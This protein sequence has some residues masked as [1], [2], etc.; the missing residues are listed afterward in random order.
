MRAV[1][2]T[3][4]KIDGDRCIQISTSLQIISQSVPTP[5]GKFV[6]KEKKR[7]GVLDIRA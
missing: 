1:P 7:V 3:D 5:T 4:R 6:R 2:N